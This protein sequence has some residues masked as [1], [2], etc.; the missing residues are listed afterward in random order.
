MYSLPVPKCRN[1]IRSPSYR[2]YTRR[3]SPKRVAG[4]AQEGAPLVV[5]PSDRA[6]GL[7]CAVTHLESIQHTVFAAESTW[8]STALG[9]EEQLSDARPEPPGSRKAVAEAL[10]SQS[11]RYSLL[12]RPLAYWR[13]ATCRSR[14]SC[15]TVPKRGIPFP[16]ST[17]TRVTMRR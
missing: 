17:G 10:V 5:R 2:R 11:K 8:W 6:S 4:R 9:S 1:S 14:T 13:V 15:G 12:T 16:M 7:G 3:G